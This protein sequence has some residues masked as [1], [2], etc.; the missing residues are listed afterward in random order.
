M[1]DS[2]SKFKSHASISMICVVLTFLFFFLPRSRFAQ[3]LQSNLT[4]LA[5]AADHG[6]QGVSFYILPFRLIR[7]VLSLSV[8]RAMR[9]P[10]ALLFSVTFRLPFFSVFVVFFSDVCM[11]KFFSMH[12]FLS[13]SFPSG[14][15]HPPNNHANPYVQI[16]SK[17]NA[18]PNN[19]RASTY[20]TSSS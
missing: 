16:E 13:T 11:S 6:K 10:R 14:A 20:S 19:G 3:R 12:L 15:A 18:L 4:W 2:D 7:R 1:C 9:L 5:A 17:H 8:G